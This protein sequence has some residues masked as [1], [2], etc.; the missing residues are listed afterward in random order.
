MAKL[1]KKVKKSKVVEKEESK[2]I[3]KKESFLKRF[4]AWWI[5]GFILPPL[6]LFLYLLWKKNRKN[7]AK[8]AGI[9]ALISTIVWLFIGLSFLINT[10]GEP[11]E[12]KTIS[13]WLEE[14]N[15]GETLVT[16]IA[17]STCPHCKNLKPIIT[18]SSNKYGYKL[19]FF[20]ADTLSEDEYKILSTTVELK[21]YEGYVP[22]VFTIVDKK[23]TN[24][25][26]GEMSD[27]ELTKFL[28][29]AKVIKD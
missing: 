27:T 6:G 2:K 13:K 20:E 14:Y 11:K 4:H 8:S 24:S 23:L 26:T 19:Y 12:E 29:E 18:A 15:N 7:D 25:T 17:S 28:K 10:N 5:V 9:G 16:V 22:Y 21:G 1:E 3:A